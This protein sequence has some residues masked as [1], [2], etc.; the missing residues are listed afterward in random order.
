MKVNRL[1]A[2]TIS[3]CIVCSLIPVSFAANNN[4]TINGVTV[5]VS[6]GTNP[7]NCSSYAS[8]VL[9]KIWSIGKVNGGMCSYY[10]PY[11]L[12]KDKTAEERTLTEA[13][14]REYIQATPLG[15]RIRI[16]PLDN[17]DKDINDYT[18]GGP[19]GHTLVLVAKNNAAGTFTVLEGGQNGKAKENT[20][21]YQD[22]VTKKSKHKYFNYITDYSAAE[23]DYKN[24]TNTGVT[25]I[26]TVNKITITY[27]PN[28]GRVSP[29]TQVIEKGSNP[30]SLPTATRDGYRFL[31]WFLNGKPEWQ[32]TESTSWAYFSDLTLF[33]LWEQDE[34]GPGHWEYRYAG[35]A[36]SD[37]RHECWCETYLKNK[38]GSANL[39]YS[40]WSTTQYSPNGSNWTCGSNCRGSHTGVSKTGSSGAPYWSEYTLPDGKN[41]Y[42]EE[43]RWVEDTPITPPSVCTQHTKGNMLYCEGVHPHR[44]YYTCSVCGK[45][46]TD[47]V[48]NYVGSCEIC[49]PGPVT[50]PGH[51]EQV[52]WTVN[53]P[54]SSDTI[55]NKEERSVE[56]S[57]SRTEYRYVGYATT[58]GKHECWCETYLRSKF[59]SAALRYSDWSTTRYSANGSAWSCGRCNG[60]HTGVDHY[61]NDG[62][63]WWAE[64]TLPD[65]RS[66][67]WEESR[68]VPAQYR[69]EYRYEKW[70]PN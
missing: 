48:A 20:Y 1:V 63:A 25:P 55:R 15:S 16:Y 24:K 27:N 23:R 60:N 62:R 43:K 17:P 56:V 14:V 32:V 64:F 8:S 44:N 35:Y 29:N 53:A 46:F 6:S 22:F 7:G 57:S 54:L 3:I 47:E 70:V 10:S 30:Q 58:N 41:Y 37:G 5:N 67:Y 34:R 59:G 51:W 13:H 18:P 40:N 28:G 50:P 2:I 45:E 4:Y 49:N 11:N 36:T 39:R 52:S 42:W 31:G 9:A 12:L 61:G 21:T 68:T 65:G 19:Y 69:T 26:P 38:F 66:F 33:A